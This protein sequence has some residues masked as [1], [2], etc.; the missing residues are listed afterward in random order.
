MVGEGG[1]ALVNNPLIQERLHATPLQVGA[2]PTKMSAGVDVLAE[3]ALLERAP[4]KHNWREATVVGLLR[5]KCADFD[6]VLGMSTL[7]TFTTVV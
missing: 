2:V 6:L 7:S 4:C 3:T 5:A 1:G